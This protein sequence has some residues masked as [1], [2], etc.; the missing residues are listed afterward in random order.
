MLLVPTASRL[1]LT[2]SVACAVPPVTVNVA[3]FSTVLPRLKATVPVGV[4]L[5]AV[6]AAVKVV[7]AVVA[8]VLGLAVTAVVVGIRT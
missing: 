4:P 7:D 3:E 5:A 2:T 1:P 6:T 8:M